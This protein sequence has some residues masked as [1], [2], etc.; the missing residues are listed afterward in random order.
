MNIK[1]RVFIIVMLSVVSSCA[2][3]QKV[4]GMTPQQAFSDPLVAELVV[5]A[6]QNDFQKVDEKVQAGADVNTIGADGVTP[7][8]WQVYLR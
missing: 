6:T 3:G 7:L 8:I 4:G 2:A 1:H 5:A